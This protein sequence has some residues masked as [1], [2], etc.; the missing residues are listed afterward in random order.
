MPWYYKQLRDCYKKMGENEKADIAQE[1]AGLI[2][3]LDDELWVCRAK[4][5]V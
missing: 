3:P 5:H 4:K 1:K 2:N